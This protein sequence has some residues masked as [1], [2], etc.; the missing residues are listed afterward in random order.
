MQFYSYD[1]V[2]VK[3]GVTDPENG[4]NLSGLTGRVS[5]I[6]YRNEGWPITV[7]VYMDEGVVEYNFSVHEIELADGE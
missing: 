1:K 2:V 3:D 6:G 5:K 4:K 7:D